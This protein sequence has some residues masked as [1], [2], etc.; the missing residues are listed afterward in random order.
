MTT[1]HYHSLRRRIERLED[2][3]RPSPAPRIYLCWKNAA[4]DVVGLCGPGVC[5]FAEDHPPDTP[6]PPIPCPWGL[7]PPITATFRTGR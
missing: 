5:W 2:H 4:G 7:P 6:P 3:F 1:L